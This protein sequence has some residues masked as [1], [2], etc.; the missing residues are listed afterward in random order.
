MNP[1]GNIHGAEA[2]KKGECGFAYLSGLS[3]KGRSDRPLLV[4]PLIS[5]TDRFDPKA[6]KPSCAVVLRV[7]GSVAQTKLD[8]DGHALLGG[9]NA[10]D[11]THPIWEG[12]P[13]V[14]VWPE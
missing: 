14:I 11:S 5:G 3:S 4:T 13:P 2:L 8:Q 6:F 9:K 7:D 1:D 12:Q 10:L